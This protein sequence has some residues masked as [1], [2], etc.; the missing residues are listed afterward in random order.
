MSETNHVKLDFETLPDVAAGT[1]SGEL[2]ILDLK[3]AAATMIE[4]LEKHPTP[5]RVHRCLKMV[6][7]ARPGFRR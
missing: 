1:C 2:S 7:R 4:G 3:A 5:P 6:W